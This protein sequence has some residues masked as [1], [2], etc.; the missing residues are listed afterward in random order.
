MDL[1]KLT[2]FNLAKTKLNWLAQRQSVLAQNL[3][4]ADTPG[5]RANDVRPIDFKQEM[6]AQMTVARQTKATLTHA[7]HMKGTIPERGPFLVEADQRAYE[8]KPDGNSVVLEDQMFKV[9]E[10]GGQY[11]LATN[12]FQK[13]IRL[14]KLALGKNG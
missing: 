12:L 11:T 3:A 13:N 5:Y 14:L 4:N 10:V 2:F 1:N 8:T 9:S 6:R 7:D